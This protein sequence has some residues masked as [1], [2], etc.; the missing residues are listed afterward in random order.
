MRAC[1]EERIAVTPRRLRAL[2]RVAADRY[3]SRMRTLLAERAENEPDGS[4][5]L[6]VRALGSQP[7]LA[8]FTATSATRA[9]SRSIA[10]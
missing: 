8:S 5:A 1:G 6:G 2:L 10:A 4:N 7:Q 9:P 3:A